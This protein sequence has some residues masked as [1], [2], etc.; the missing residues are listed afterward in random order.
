MILYNDKSDIVQYNIIYDNDNSS[1]GYIRFIKTFSVNNA[2]FIIINEIEID[3]DLENEELFFIVTIGNPNHNLNSIA[4]LLL[5]FTL[6]EKIEKYKYKI[7]FE[8][9]IELLNIQYDNLN[10][11][12]VVKS[13]SPNVKKKKIYIKCT[14]GHYHDKIIRQLIATKKTYI[15]SICIINLDS[16][17]DLIL[18]SKNENITVLLNNIDFYKYKILY[19]NIEEYKC[20]YGYRCFNINSKYLEVIEKEDLKKCYYIV[21]SSHLS[22]QYN[23]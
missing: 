7:P 20:I 5:P 23:N 3:E 16:A 4:I 15:N 2:D 14:I 1:N 9:K 17:I 18:S 8:K 11:G 22:S 21:E 10:V 19:D 6:L 12:V 13:N